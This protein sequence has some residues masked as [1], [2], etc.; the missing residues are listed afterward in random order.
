MSTS[1]RAPKTSTALNTPTSGSS[2]NPCGIG[3]YRIARPVTGDDPPGVK[4]S[5]GVRGNTKSDEAATPGRNRVSLVANQRA[6]GVCGLIKSCYGD[7]GNNLRR[8]ASTAAGSM[9]GCQSYSSVGRPN[10]SIAER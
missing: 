5:G 4:R 1:I 3:S 9:K 10:R 6:V 2:A 8:A 7:S